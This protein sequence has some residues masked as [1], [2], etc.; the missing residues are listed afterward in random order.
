MGFPVFG[1]IGP[2]DGGSFGFLE[3]VAAAYNF[4]LAMI[5]ILR[6]FAVFLCKERLA[7]LRRLIC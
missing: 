5:E 6:S 7:G 1:S 4:S 2:V 3:L